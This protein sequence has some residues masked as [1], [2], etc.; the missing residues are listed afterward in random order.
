ML[1]VHQQHKFYSSD[2]MNVLICS[3]YGELQVAE[4]IKLLKD[5]GLNCVLFERYRKDQFITYDYQDGGSCAFL[6]VGDTE[7]PLNSITFPVVWYRPKP[8]LYSELPGCNAKVEEKFCAQEWGVILRSLD[9]YLAQS[10]WINPIVNSRRASNKAFQLRIASDMGL[11]IPQTIITNKAEDALIL[12]K[13]NR[14]IYKTLSSFF[15][16]TQAIYTNEI[17]LKDIECK[18]NQIAMAPGIFQKYI[19][20]QYE[21]RITIIGDSLFI[22]RINSQLTAESAIDWRRK[23]DSSLYEMGDI[24]KVTRDKL[25]ALHKRLGLIYAAYDFIVDTDGN[26]IFIECNPS[27]QWLWLENALGLEVSK[28]MVKELNLT[29]KR[30]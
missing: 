8:I 21:L 28:M 20:K 22:A 13:N 17:T 9:V 19:E 26:E 27:G 2:M 7:Y 15:T 10:K 11:P 3:Q 1:A 30:C 4:V 14:V 23:P 29:G 12:F 6:R 18:K 5:Q 24:S 16:A 25:I